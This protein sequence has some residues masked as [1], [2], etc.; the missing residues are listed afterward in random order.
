MG[1]VFGLYVLSA[2]SSMMGEM[3]IENITPFK[4]FDASY[5]VANGAYDAPLIYLSFALIVISVA[6]SYI[7]Y[8]RRDIHSV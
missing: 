5:I 1:L 2:F 6:G 8:T 3:P 4:H 7:L